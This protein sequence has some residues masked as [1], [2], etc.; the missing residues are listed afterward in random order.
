VAGVNIL[1]ASAVVDISR[2]AKL[3]TLV[4][5]KDI[6]PLDSSSLSVSTLIPGGPRNMSTLG[7]CLASA[8]MLL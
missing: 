6:A 8:E 2:D 3:A 4:V 1:N 7:F 5:K